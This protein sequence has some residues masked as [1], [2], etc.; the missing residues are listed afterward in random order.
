MF[1]A[2][3]FKERERRYVVG[4]VAFPFS[5][6]ENRNRVVQP[7]NLK[8]NIYASVNFKPRSLAYNMQ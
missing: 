2:P 6:R 8:V 1:R 7:T 5:P 4:L 3:L